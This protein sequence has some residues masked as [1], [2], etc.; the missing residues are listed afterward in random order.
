MVCSPRQHLRSL[1]PFTSD[2]RCHQRHRSCLAEAEMGPAPPAVC[3]HPELFLLSCEGGLVSD[4]LLQA[5]I[6]DQD[7]KTWRDYCLCALLSVRV[8]VIVCLHRVKQICWKRP[9]EWLHAAG[10]VYYCNVIF[11]KREVHYVDLKDSKRKKKQ[12]IIDKNR[13]TKSHHTQTHVQTISK[14]LNLCF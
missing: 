10:S 3:R 8:C 4:R 11:E 12:I 1:S 2:H 14:T 9:D 13:K 6:W 7:W 5:C